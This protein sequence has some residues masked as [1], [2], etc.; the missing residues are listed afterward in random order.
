MTADT[1]TCLVDYVAGASYGLN[2]IPQGW[3]DQLRGEWPLGSGQLWHT[4]DF[5]HLADRLVELEGNHL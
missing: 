1:A 3:R 2:A 4:P 5:I